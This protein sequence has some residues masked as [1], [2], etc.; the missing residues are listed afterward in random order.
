MADNT[1]QCES[2][3]DPSRQCEARHGGQGQSSPGW[4]RKTCRGGQGKTWNGGAVRGR[5]LFGMA[6]TERLG[7]ARFGRARDGE[8]DKAGQGTARPDTAGLG[9]A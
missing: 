2:R 3:L 6:D 9:G 5:T 7:S 8:A 4:H 1:G